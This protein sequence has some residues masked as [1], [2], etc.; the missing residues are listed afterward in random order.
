[1]VYIVFGKLLYLLW[2]FYATEQIVIVANVQRLKY[3]LVTLL[4]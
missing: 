1:M 4:L 2:H 3:N